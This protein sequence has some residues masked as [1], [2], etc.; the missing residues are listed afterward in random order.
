MN[1]NYHTHNEMCGHAGGTLEEY[2]QC[3]IKNDLKEIGM[4]DHIPYPGDGFG[5]RMPYARLDEYIDTTLQLKEMYRDQ[6]QVLLG[7][8]SEYFSDYDRYYQRLLQEKGVEYLILG[9]HFYMTRDGKLANVYNDM[10]D[11]EAC[12]DYA[13]SCMEAMNTGYFAY[14]AHPDLIFVN[15]FPLDNAVKRTVDYIINESLKHDYILELN[16]N[17][18]RRG[19]SQFV[20]GERYPY[21]TDFFWNE[22]AK[23]KVRVIIGADCHSLDVLC[24]WATE[25]AENMAGELGLNLIEKMW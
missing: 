24:D 3:A 23:S 12:M 4:S 19:K 20:T 2:V 1:C 9:Q 16:A 13:K 6:I 5:Y 10:P 17:G 25:Q 11:T 8:E 7:L 21:P 18:F 14:L 15:D 22:V